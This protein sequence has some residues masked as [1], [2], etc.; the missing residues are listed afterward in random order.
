VDGFQEAIMN[1]EEFEKELEEME[2][3]SEASPA[4]EAHR[5]ACASCAELV[6]DLN[7][8]RT[9]ARQM[10]SLEQP[11]ERVWEGIHLQLQASGLIKDPPRRRFFER[12]PAMAWFSRLSMSTAYA[13]VFL[14]ALGVVYVYSILSPRVSPLPLP[15][16]PNPPFAQLFE[17]VPPEKRAMYAS[18]LNQVDTSIQRLQ[19]FLAAHPEDPFARQQLFTIYQEKS[20]LW[21]DL[22]RWQDFSEA[23]PQSTIDTIPQALPASAKP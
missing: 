9:Q 16:P 20:R 11:S 21:E 1:C 13:A 15:P 19:T 22:V 4:A 7:S 17:K 6:E 8:V 3:D 10:L 12:L 14:A 23:A 18:N 5:R 2:D